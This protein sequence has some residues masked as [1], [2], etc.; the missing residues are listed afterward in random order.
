[1]SWGTSISVASE[2][3]QAT[4]L[5]LKIH[6]MGGGAGD[7]AVAVSLA[8]SYLLPHL[9]GVG[10]DFL[11]LYEKG[12]SVKARPRPRLGAGRHIRK[13]PPSRASTRRLCR[14]SVGPLGAT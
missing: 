13:G 6:E 12:G 10:G 5:G 7:V 1:M 2:S 3:F 8:L 4:Y 11:V 14:A 9:N